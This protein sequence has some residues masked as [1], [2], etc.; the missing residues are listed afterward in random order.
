MSDDPYTSPASDPVPDTLDDCPG[1]GARLLR[2]NVDGTLRWLPDDASSMQKFIGGKRVAG[3]PPLSISIG[4]RKQEA[5]HC[6]SCGV[7]I[8]IP[9]R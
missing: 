2:G 5:K 7:T 8:I 1:C 4:S 3:P 9:D 6:P